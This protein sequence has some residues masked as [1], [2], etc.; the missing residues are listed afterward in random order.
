MKTKISKRNFHQKVENMEQKF[1]L[2]LDRVYQ[3]SS[4]MAADKTY[5]HG[6]IPFVR[7]GQWNLNSKTVGSAKLN[8][9]LITKIGRASCRERV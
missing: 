4:N 8:E 5:S 1:M 9:L 6:G 7:K 3:L 2:T